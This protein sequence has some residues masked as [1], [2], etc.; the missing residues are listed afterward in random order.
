[1]RLFIKICQQNFFP[2]STAIVENFLKT[3]IDI[4]GDIPDII[5][6]V[7]ILTLQRHF[8]FPDGIENGGMVSA[9]FLTDVRQT[10]IGQLADQVDS[11]L[12]GLCR[13]LI[14]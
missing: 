5:L 11:Y 14:L 8:H 1:M 4:G 9:K 7:G 3:G 12:P 6:E 13:S 2:L 10:Q